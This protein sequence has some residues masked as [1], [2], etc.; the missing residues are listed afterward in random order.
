MKEG[1]RQY[2]VNTECRG[3]KCL[4]DKMGQD[5]ATHRQHY[6]LDSHC[7]GCA[8][9]FR[10]PLTESKPLERD[11]R[12]EVQISTRLVPDKSCGTDPHCQEIQHNTIQ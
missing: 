10:S 6:V 2:T 12:R 7:L 8:V 1:C 4:I 9:G 3:W 5:K 11:V